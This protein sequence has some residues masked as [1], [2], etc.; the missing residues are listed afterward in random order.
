MFNPFIAQSRPDLVRKQ[1]VRGGGQNRAEV[2]QLVDVL[3]EGEQLGAS[4]A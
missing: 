1:G 2:A 4:G 3:P